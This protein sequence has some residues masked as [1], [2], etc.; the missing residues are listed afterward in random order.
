MQRRNF[1]TNVGMEFKTPEEFFLQQAAQPFSRDFEP[2]DYL[3][4]LSTTSTDAG[5]LQKFCH[6]STSGS[7]LN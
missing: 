3:S 1:A 5:K 4:T 7:H 2:R 6:I